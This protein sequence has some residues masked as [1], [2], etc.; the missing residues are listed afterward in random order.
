MNLSLFGR[1]GLGGLIVLFADE[2]FN[3]HNR[4]EALVQ[5][6]F[7]DIAEKLNED[8]LSLSFAEG[9]TGAG[10]Y[11]NYL[12]RSGQIQIDLTSF[13]EQVDELVFNDAVK[14]L[15]STNHDFLYGAIGNG[16]YLVERI[17]ENNV[18]LY[19]YN[20]V[21]LLMDL[22]VKDEHGNL[23]WV[24]ANSKKTVNLSLSHGCA[25]KV[26]FF[27]KLLKSNRKNSYLKNCLNK[28]ANFLLSSKNTVN[29]GSMF[30]SI[31]ADGV[32]NDCSRLA[33]CYGDLGI[34]IALWQA[35]EVLNDQQF[36]DEAVKIYLNSLH[37]VNFE[38]TQICD[39][40]ICHG[41]S[42][43]ALMYNRMYKST[44]IKE[45]RDAALFWCQKTIDF[46]NNPNV[47]ADY[48]SWN[49]NELGWQLDDSL[50]T[51]STGVDLTI[52]SIQSERDYNWDSCILLC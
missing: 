27:S 31:L 33:W 10:W 14:N 18:Q 38:E 44:K 19:L 51:G 25:S 23:Y 3:F 4:H 47:T 41:S 43:I 15:K 29:C 50:L 21:R 39:A 12:N 26:V 11:L 28:S 35:G 42:G 52:L 8:K 30:P 32:G 5:G 40:G 37:R 24:E 16:I 2:Y 49:G 46:K 36:R 9:I 22:S 7:N 20:L 6:A 48:R 17:G 1:N 34:G 45:F 13:L